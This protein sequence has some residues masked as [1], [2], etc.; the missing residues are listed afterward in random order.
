MINHYHEQSLK[1]KG[2]MRLRKLQSGKWLEPRLGTYPCPPEHPT[3][4]SVSINI[5]RPWDRRKIQDPKGDPKATE[6]WKNKQQLK[7]D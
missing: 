4:N 1:I 7:Y 5:W 3:E 6:P 2:N